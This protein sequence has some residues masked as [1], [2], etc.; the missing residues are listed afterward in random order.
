MKTIIIGA[1]APGLTAAVT[2]LQAR[3][4]VMV[5]DSNEKPGGV[6]QGWHKTES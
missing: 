2:L 4:K 5:L 6:L 1:G 3:H